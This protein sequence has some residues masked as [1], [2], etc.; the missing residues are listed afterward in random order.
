MRTPTDH[1]TLYLWHTHAL[2]GA[3]MPMHDG[4]PQCG[5]Y[6]RR[7]VAGGPWVP[8][9]VWVEQPIDPRTGQLIADETVHC[10]ID[11]EYAD[12]FDEWVSLAKRP[13]PQWKYHEMIQDRK[14]IAR[15][16]PTN[17]VLATHSAPRMFDLLGRI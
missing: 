7:M 10:E 1:S 6:L 3:H 4:D 8:A 16:D 15:H 2:S 9:V 5:W 11:G 12:P 13:I 14:W 17:P